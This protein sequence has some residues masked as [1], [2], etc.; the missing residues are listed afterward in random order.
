ML[1]AALTKNFDF[2]LTGEELAKMP[3]AG[4]SELVEGEMVY[5][6]PTGYTHGITEIGVGSILRAFVRKNNLGIV[7]T[8]EVGI[9]TGR[10]P[11]TIRAADVIYISH[12]RMAKVESDSFLD[13]TPELVVEILSPGDRWYEVSDK[14][15]EYFSAG[16][17]SV[18]LVNPR[19]KQVFVYHSPANVKCYGQDETLS[20]ETVLPGFAVATEEFFN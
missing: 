5:M 8:G 19:R 4:P 15:A 2:L 20:D 16:V 7:M 3:D 1:S 12:E 17:K 18:W 14:V 9:Y 6:S 10:D 13:I 11:D